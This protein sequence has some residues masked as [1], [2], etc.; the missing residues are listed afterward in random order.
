MSVIPVEFNLTTLCATV[1]GWRLNVQIGEP[2]ALNAYIWAFLLIC[3]LRVLTF[4][5]A[6]RLP[7][8]TGD[9]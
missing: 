9:A 6:C 8:R 3:G 1:L 7:L 5:A 2:A 4:L